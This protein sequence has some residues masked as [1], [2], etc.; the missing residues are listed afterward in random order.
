[1]ASFCFALKILCLPTKETVT[2]SPVLCLNTH[3]FDNEG[4]KSIQQACYLEHNILNALEYICI[5]SIWAND[6]VISWWPLRFCPSAY[7]WPQ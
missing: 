7:V 2:L 3:Y 5:D 6:H 1:M 4:E